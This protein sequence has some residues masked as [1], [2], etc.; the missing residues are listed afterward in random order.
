ML[1]PF[2]RAKHHW[3]RDEG[4][5]AIAALAE[6][7]GEDAFYI[8]DYDLDYR[9]RLPFEAFATGMLASDHHLMEPFDTAVTRLWREFPGSYAVDALAR[10]GKTE[11]EWL[12]AGARDGLLSTD[13]AD[14]GRLAKV[15]LAPIPEPL[16]AAR[17]RAEIAEAEASDAWSK[18]IRAHP[19][20][21]AN[22]FLDTVFYPAEVMAP[23]MVRD[24]IH[25]IGEDQPEALDVVADTLEGW[26][27][28]EVARIGMR[29]EAG[30]RDCTAALIDALRHRDAGALPP[31]CVPSDAT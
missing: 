1:S 23:E 10:R 30:N 15:V 6:V 2:L 22:V 5:Q 21:T 12:D 27:P 4:R 16:D 18:F 19:S 7:A 20:V 28:E 26:D 17:L 31:E 3:Y 25:V 13:V 29:V 14:L 8:S 11:A 9:M 24:R